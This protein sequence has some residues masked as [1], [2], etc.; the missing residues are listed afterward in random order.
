MISTHPCYIIETTRLMFYQQHYIV[1]FSLSPCSSLRMMS[2]SSTIVF[3][4]LF[5]NTR[6]DA[7]RIVKSL[8]RIFHDKWLW[9]I[10]LV[11]FIL[12][13]N[14]EFGICH[15]LRHL[16]SFTLYSVKFL[17]TMLQS[18]NRNLKLTI[19]LFVTKKDNY[20]LLTATLK[21]IRYIRF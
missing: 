12:F 11:D 10:L 3:T 16:F 17:T 8:I 21:G 20:K 19:S 14:N 18:L 1:I 2:K 9:I 15:T 4:F 6:T 7:V 13:A 5:V